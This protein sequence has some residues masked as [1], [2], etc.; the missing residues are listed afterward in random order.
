MIKKNYIV[1][2]IY[3]L[4]VSNI[5]IGKDDL[6]FDKIKA[7]INK[8][9]NLFY[10][11]R[12][13]RRD[14]ATI[15]DI[16]NIRHGVVYARTPLEMNDPFDSMIG[17][18]E[19]KIYE[20]FIDLALDQID[21]SLDSNIR[22]IIRSILKYRIVGE[23]VGFIEALNKL[24]KYIFTQSV[25][26]HVKT[27]NLPLFI[28]GN[29]DKLYRKCPADVKK[30]FDKNSF[31]T[32]SIIIKDYQNVQIEEKMITDALK[33]EDTLDLLE[34]K[35]IEIRDQIYLPFIRNFLSKLTVVC[36]SASGWDNQLMWA[37][38]AN[39]YSGICVEYDF[40]KM[41]K[42]IGF[43]YPVNYTSERPTLSLKDLG[44][45]K[46]EKDEDGK[47]KTEETDMGAIFSYMLAKNKC[48]DYEEEW[49]IINTGEDPYSPIFVDTPF[50][51]SITLGLKID[52]MCKQ[53]IW[54]VCQERG[55]ECYQLVLNPSDYVLTREKLSEESF[56]FDEKK[57]LEYINLL[58]A[59]TSTLSEN[60]SVNSKTVIE[61]VKKG[62]IEINAIVNILTNTLDFLSDAYFLKASFKRYCR[63]KN[64]Q[65]T[66]LAQGTTIGTAIIQINEF[67]SKAKSSAVSVNDSTTRFVLTNKITIND[68]R[69]INK[70]TSEILEMVEKHDEQ[71]WFDDDTEDVIVMNESQE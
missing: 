50:I 20:E 49:R 14:A 18:S 51:K 25:I 59:H 32:F 52:E 9:G 8:A 63:N 23:T 3:T 16:E 44:F 67:I 66:E 69:T 6:S 58:A 28:V 39:S 35:I 5:I 38:Y 48:W 55:I 10:Q 1:F 53:L 65:T 70:L 57:E 36:F 37:H 62:T 68:Y 4:E 33:M 31:T 47:I 11:Y 13:C 7:N 45:Q 30:Y 22:L 17:F 64:V 56:A 43:I 61:G 26:A 2:N 12:A 29:V 34:D 54:D 60:T 41:D 19:E 24:K 71:K 27:A 21:S 46:F 42:F 15:Y 40:E